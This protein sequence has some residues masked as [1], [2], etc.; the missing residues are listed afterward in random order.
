MGYE[1]C[2]AQD[3][4]RGLWAMTA[5]WFCIFLLLVGL[6]WPR[7]REVLTQLLLPGDGAVT[8]AALE[9]FARDLRTGEAL[10]AAAESFCRIV[11]EGAS[12]APG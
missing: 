7:G 8:V 12:L 1:I 9:V 10:G 3:E 6:C 2:Y 5:G 11:L 4:G